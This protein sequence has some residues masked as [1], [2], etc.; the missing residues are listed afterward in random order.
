M[1]TKT[2]ND[3]FKDFDSWNG[4][5]KVIHKI[6]KIDGKDAFVI[7]SQLRLID[8]KRL[9]NKVGIIHGTL[10]DKIRKAVKDML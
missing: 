7:I 6:G 1:T 8:T 9:V 2:N 10:F 3:F 5:K 4:R